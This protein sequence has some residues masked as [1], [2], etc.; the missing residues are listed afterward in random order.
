M[1]A[2]AET[3][4]AVTV[5][6]TCFNY[7]RYL[8][9]CLRSVTDQTWRDLEVVVVDDGSTDDTAEVARRWLGDPRVRYVAQANSGQAKA[10][11]L[12]VRQARGEFVAFLDADDL[13]HPAKLERQLP[14]FE[15]P[16]VQVVYSRAWYIDE[17][18]ARIDFQPLGEYLQPRRGF[19]ADLL[20][21]DNFIPFS[22]S[23]LRRSAFERVGG[24]DESLA[25]AIDWDLWLRLSLD[26]AFEY[27]DEALIAYR[28]GH[29]DQ[30]SR[31]REVRFECCDA[32]LKKFLALAG[33]RLTP[34]TLRKARLYSW[35]TRGRHFEATSKR[36]ALGYYLRAIARHPFHVPA[37]KGLVRV[38]LPAGF[39]VGR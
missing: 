25:M 1:S 4:P 28:M 21:F 17:I 37:Y 13:W 11:N 12:G 14:L 35:V 23:V 30:M 19:V 27:V 16:Q 26:G 9:G 31:S 33:R 18:G 34:H 15:N 38:A 7:G 10:K 3:K 39:G 24:F 32:V 5:V 20:L 2:I 8:D 36:H 29:P 6:V 22:S